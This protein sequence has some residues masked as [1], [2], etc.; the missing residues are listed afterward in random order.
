MDDILARTGSTFDR[1]EACLED[2]SSFARLARRAIGELGFKD[3]LGEDPDQ[4]EEEPDEMPDESEGDDSQN[5]EGLDAETS[6]DS[7]S[8]DSEGPEGADETA[9][10]VDDMDFED[11]LSD[12][13]LEI[14]DDPQ[15]PQYLPPA[16]SQADPNYK[17]FTTEFDEIV[18]AEML[19]ETPE[20]ERL[21]KNLEQQL[22]PFKGTVG[23]LANKLQR[24]LLAQ[25]S[26]S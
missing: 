8:L 14:P 20:L 23:R 3:Q 6:E 1:L 2:Q 9:L 11:M 12:E 7:E 5:A 17:V 4:A 22:E 10:P 16:P 25:Q 18:R 19:A 13:Q 26:R 21:R 15:N 24:R